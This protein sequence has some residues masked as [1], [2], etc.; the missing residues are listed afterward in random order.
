MKS[1]DCFAYQNLLAT[2]CL[3]YLYLAPSPDQGNT[4]CLLLLATLFLYF[5]SACKMMSHLSKGLGLLK[6]RLV[7]LKY[8]PRTFLVQPKK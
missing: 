7:L 4:I 8:V 2:V 3:P 5:Q 6:P 1:S